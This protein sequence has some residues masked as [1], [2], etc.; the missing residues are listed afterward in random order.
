MIFTN[1]MT[2]TMTKMT[3]MTTMMWL[4][5]HF[6]RPGPKAREWRWVSF[7]L[8]TVW[9]ACLIFL[10]LSHPFHWQVSSRGGD[11]REEKSSRNKNHMAHREL[12]SEWLSKRSDQT[13]GSKSYYWLSYV[14]TT[15]HAEVY[16]FIYIF[17]CF[18]YFFII[19]IFFFF[20]LWRLS[21]VNVVI[22]GKNNSDIESCITT[23][24]ISSNY[25]RCETSV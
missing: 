17:V 18:F 23:C 2:E 4:D 25:V 21:E 3:T 24:D 8:I 13:W 1:P 20:H 6:Q 5:H 7:M 22:C 11:G 10:F 19:I 16:L 9:L 14:L 12:L 15:D